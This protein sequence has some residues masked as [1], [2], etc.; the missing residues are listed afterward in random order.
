LL[1]EDKVTAVEWPL[2]FLLQEA[3]KRGIETPDDLRPRTPSR[4]LID[5]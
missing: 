2:A 4:H 3:R 1:A 5:V